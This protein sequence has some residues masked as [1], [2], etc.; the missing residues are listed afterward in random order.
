MT[1]LK[2]PLVESQIEFYETL[3]AFFADVSKPA[4]A[5]QSGLDTGAK[6]P[7]LD[8]LDPRLDQRLG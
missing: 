5:S 1:G 2:Y 6:R 8:E 3:A 7:G 4:H